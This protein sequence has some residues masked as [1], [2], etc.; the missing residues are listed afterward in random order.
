MT[1]DL[2]QIRTVRNFLNKLDNTNKRDYLLQLS[3]EAQQELRKYPELFLFDKQI[4]P[5]GNWR[6]CLLRCGRR[7][8]KSISGSAWIASKVINGAKSLGLCGEDYATVVQVMV[9]NII[10]W[11][12]KGEAIYNDKHHKIVFERLYKGAEIYCYSSDKEVKGPSLEYLWCDELAN[13]SDRLPDKVRVRFDSVDTAVSVGKH[14]QTIITT[15]PRSFPI[16]WDYQAKL[17]AHDPNYI[18]ITGTMFDNPFL[19][20]GYRQKELQKYQYDKM[21]LRQEIYGDLVMSNPEALFQ[22]EW[23]DNNRIIAKNNTERNHDK[24]IKYF[25]QQV[26][27]QKIFLKRLAISVDPSGSN[28]KTS[29]EVGIIFGC[30][31]INN[32]IDILYDLSG[33]HSPDQWA[34]IVRDCFRQYHTMF[35]KLPFHIICETNFGGDLVLSNL[36]AVDHNLRPFLKD[37]KA[38]KSKMVRAEPAAAKYQ[39]DKVHHIGYFSQLEREMTNYTGNADQ[40]SPNHMDAMV[41]LINEFIVVPQFSN[42][43]VRLLNYM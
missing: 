17:D 16:F 43:D 33:R 38:F 11:F 42:R 31:E 26:L 14:P 36:M 21:R 22:Q 34:R 4:I 9:K 3:K 6:Y 41:H 19:S 15:T 40:S 37:V 27:D 2:S 23:I 1:L 7:F 13:W 32:E 18:M 39:R 20:E 30:Q 24:D 25:F 10:S 29:D 28:K 12:P 5:E 8:G 35:P